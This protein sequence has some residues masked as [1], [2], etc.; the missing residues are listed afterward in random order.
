VA[1]RFR[2]ASPI[3]HALLHGERES[4]VTIIDVDPAGIDRGKMLSKASVVR[5]D[6]FSARLGRLLNW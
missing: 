5:F 2:G 1:C 4:G 3:Q 6:K